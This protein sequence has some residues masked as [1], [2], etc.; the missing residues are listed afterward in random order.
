VLLAWC[1][2]RGWG[3]WAGDGRF[4]RRTEQGFAADCQKRPLRS[5]FRQRLKPGVRH[6]K[7]V[8]HEVY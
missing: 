7:E 6:D 3:R 2:G 8:G 5:R 4:P 1:W